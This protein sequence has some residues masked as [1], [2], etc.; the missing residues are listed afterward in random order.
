MIG[1]TQSVERLVMYANFSAVCELP[2]NRSLIE[3]LMAKILKREPEFFSNNEAFSRFF[4][5]DDYREAPDFECM[6]AF[7]QD[8]Y[9]EGLDD[10]SSPGRNYVLNRY[11]MPTLPRERYR[12]TQMYDLLESLSDSIDVSASIHPK[13]P[14]DAVAYVEQSRVRAEELEALG[15]RIL[16]L[17]RSGESS[18]NE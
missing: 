13:N 9:M 3:T 16:E 11:G 8:L 12:G 6:V 4:D 10:D 7:L 15:R 17:M 1:L 5:E 14:D 2:S 18:P